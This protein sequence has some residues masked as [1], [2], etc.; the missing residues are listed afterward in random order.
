MNRETVNRQVEF[1]EDVR[2]RADMVFVPVREN[3]RGQVVAIFFEK[4]EI[5][6]RDIDAIRRFLGK[7]HSGIDDDHLVAIADA[8]AVHPELADAAQWNYFD[9]VHLLNA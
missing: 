1:F 8:H 2:E 5:R 7:A 4:I 6:D 9:L 3:D